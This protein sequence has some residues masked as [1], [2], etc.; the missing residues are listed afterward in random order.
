MSD[1]VIRFGILGCGTIARF[2]ADAI[3]SLVDAELVGCTSVIREEALQFSEK[4]NIK[5]YADYET[6]LADP[7]IDA[8][9]ICTPSG[10]H[11]DNAL[12]ALR[13]KKHVVLEKPMAFTREQ[14]REICAE[15]EKSGCKLTVI[16]QLRFSENVRKVKKL[17]EENAFGKLVFCDLYM[18]YW[19]SP[20][21]YAA[22]DWRGTRKLDGGGALMNQGI[23]GIDMLLHLVGDAKVVRAKN[24]TRHHDIEVEDA[25]V[26]M[27]E[28]ENGAMGV[29]EG[30][31]CAWPGFERRLEINGTRGCVVLVEGEIE[32]LIVDGET[33]IDG[34]KGAVGNTASDPTAF[35]YDLHAAQIKNLI[36]AIHGEEELMIPATEGAR[37]VSLIE[38]I[39]EF[40]CVKE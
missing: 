31:T 39:Y 1:N 25:S 17:V 7:N 27:L 19:R 12:Q 5:A 29:I 15:V 3:G 6:M 8:V 21:Y 33:L 23:H 34:R 38:D 28:F 18:K 20:E 16:C 26:A 2:H 35:A 11:A 10:F 22:S 30:S 9:C 36:G 40:G 32:K 4:Y 37:A 14:T 24:V 13:A